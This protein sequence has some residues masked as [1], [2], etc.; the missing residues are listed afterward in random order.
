VEENKRKREK[1]LN[2]TFTKQELKV[3]KELAK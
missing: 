2:K 3:G 1:G